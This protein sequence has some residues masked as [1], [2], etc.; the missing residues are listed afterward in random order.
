MVLTAFSYFY[1]NYID[2]LS[3][4]SPSDKTFANKFFIVF[5]SFSIKNFILSCFRT[6]V[7]KWFPINLIKI[8]SALKN[9]VRLLNYSKIPSNQF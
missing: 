2:I 1:K 9:N 8:V 7:F 6:Y 5:D 3:E 4:I